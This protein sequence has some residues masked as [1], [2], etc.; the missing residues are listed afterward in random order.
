MVLYCAS[1]SADPVEHEQ[2]RLRWD[3]SWRSF[4]AAHAATTGLGALFA[5]GGLAIP[6]DPNRWS[7]PNGFD[8]SVRDA[9]RLER[10]EARFRARDASDVLLALAINQ[11]LVDAL[12][13]AWWRHDAREVALQLAL[14]DAEVIAINTAVNTVAS[15]LFSRRRPYVAELCTGSSATELEDCRSS[16]RYRS[17]YSGHTSTS[18]AA[19]AVN[20]MHHAYLPLYRGGALDS[21][22]CAAGFATAAAVGT[23]RVASDQHWMSDVL[24]GAAMGTATGLLVP[25]LLH[26]RGDRRAPS[27][28]TL[29]LVPTGLG[30]ALGGTL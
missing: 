26:Y 23:L 11:L 17:F 30:V 25:W 24:T 7:S 2:P 21:L 20:C 10:D 27:A 14:I 8:G 9:L 28:R 6:V 12:V 22:A 16:R 1:A 15:A 19:A 13:V 29:H 3:S 5:L 18:F 4:G